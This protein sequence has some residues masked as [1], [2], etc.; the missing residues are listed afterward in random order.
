[1]RLSVKLEF[2]LAGILA[3]AM[4]TITMLRKYAEEFDRKLKKLFHLHSE[5]K[6][7]IVIFSFGAAECWETICIFDDV[8]YFANT[9]KQHHYHRET[10]W[11][12][13]SPSICRLVTVHVHTVDLSR[14][15]GTSIASINIFPAAD[16]FACVAVQAVRRTLRGSAKPDP[17]SAI[18]DRTIPTIRRRS[19][20]RL[21]TPR[22]VALSISPG[23]V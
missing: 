17:P 10:T 20:D 19:P 14:I 18:Q 6:K 23:H 16:L 5:M 7:R 12:A 11:Y 2:M 15:H 9:E 13:A 1:M 3:K 22:H 21:S 8:R 4:L